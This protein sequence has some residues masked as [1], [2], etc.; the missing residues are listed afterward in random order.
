MLVTGQHLHSYFCLFFFAL[1]ALALERTLQSIEF[2]S[3]EHNT[4]ERQFTGYKL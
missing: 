4:G 3:V 1:A 2:T